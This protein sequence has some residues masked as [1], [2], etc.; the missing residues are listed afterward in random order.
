MI[1]INLLT[2]E[3]PVHTAGHFSVSMGDK[4]GQIVALLVL[5]ACA[6]YI[7]WDYVRLKA[8]DERLQAELVA[9]RAEKQRLAPV[10]KQVERFDLRKKELQQ[11]VTLIEDLRQKQAGP[12]HMLDEI[13]NSLPDRLWL[14]EM[15]QTGDDVQ[16]DGRTSSLSSLADLVANLEASGYFKKPVEIIGS[17]EER[18]NEKDLIKFSIKATFEM[19]GSKASAPASGAAAPSTGKRLAE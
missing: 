1:R 19:P 13:S 10:L 4:G 8:A 17:E 5:V 15:K 3:K 9:A 12:V 16:M 2:V 14:T 6:G 7:G 11:R 18:T